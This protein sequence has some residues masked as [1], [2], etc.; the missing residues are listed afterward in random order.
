MGGFGSGWQGAKKATVEEGLTLS[1]RRLVEEQ[2]IKLGGWRAGS[3]AWSYEGQEPFAH[4][5]YE[6]NT[7]DPDD[8][9]FRIVGR[10]NGE[11]VDY[12]IR[13]MT[14]RPHFGGIRWWF[15]CPCS[16]RRAHKLH[17]A[18]GGK[19]FAHRNAY[20]L[21]YRSCQESGQY[22]GLYSRLAAQLGLS[23]MAVKAALN[24]RWFS[25]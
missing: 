6:A 23:E 3:W 5:S 25:Q 9:W 12:R 18:P 20:G 4:L 21:T 24:S 13:L 22:R 2:V 15:I 7:V 17:L 16:G 1:I 19:Y 8:A 10:V 11:P 14:T